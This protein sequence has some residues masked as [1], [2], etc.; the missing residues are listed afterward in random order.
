MYYLQSRYYNPIVGRFINADDV[1]MLNC[2]GTTNSYNLLTYCNNSPIN[3]ADFLGYKSAKTYSG[4]VGFGLQVLFSANVLC[5]QGFIGVEA[6]WFA[7]TKNNNFGNGKIPWCYWFAGGSMGLTLDFDLILSNDFLNS[8]KN[9]LKGFGLTFNI[10][11]GVTFFLI[12]ANKLKNPNDY[13]RE[14]GFTSLTT[15]GVTFSKASGSNISTYGTGFSWE[16]GTKFL[17]GISIGKKLFGFAQ[18]ASFY[19]PLPINKNAKELYS[20]VANKV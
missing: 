18:G 8:P 6:L 11:I 3:L 14:F 1:G 16:V 7:F 10:S 2:F 12:T 17:K 15:W 4:L 9:I 19:W 5:Y 20:T 13:T